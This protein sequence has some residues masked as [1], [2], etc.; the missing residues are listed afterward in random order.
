MAENAFKMKQELC[1]WRILSPT[2]RE[3]TGARVFAGPEPLRG[4]A[5]A[6][7]PGTLKGMCNA[8]DP[9]TTGLLCLREGLAHWPVMLKD[10]LN[11]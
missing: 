11:V 2:G 3:N 8:S 7:S 5:F 6:Q 1:W 10:A 9:D 4:P